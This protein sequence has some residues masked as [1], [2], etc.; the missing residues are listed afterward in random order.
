MSTLSWPSWGTTVSVQ[1]ADPAALRSARR[2]VD[3]CLRA[4]EKAADGDRARSE[5]QRLDR[6]G[7]AP[8]T[9]SPLLAD[10][11]A[12]ALDAAA[13]TEG[14]CD[15]TVGTSTAVLAARIRADQVGDRSRFPVCGASSATSPLRPAR[16]WQ[17]VRV[18][19]RRVVVP[20]GIHLDL[21][22][23]AT[24]FLASGAAVFAARHLGTGVLVDLGGDVATAGTSPSGGW[25]VAVGSP[26]G[27][28]P[29]SG[30][31]QTG[32]LQTV[33]LH[34]SD[35]LSTAGGHTVVDPRTGR[36]VPQIWR[37][38]SVRTMD[39][40]TAKAL[41]I[42]A[43]VAGQNAPELLE[44]RGVAAQLEYLDGGLLQLTGWDEQRSHGVR[45]H[46][47]TAS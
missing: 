34:P 29:A 9:V 5:I 43:H 22:A 12:A 13:M 1:T 47:A 17:H 10:L 16:G 14:A 21:S 15:P 30:G 33:R 39:C 23:T 6:S 4:G 37:R 46:L 20:V 42:A 40:V 31:P 45:R 11:V 2:L 7:G 24:A 3:L 28:D 44:S 25:R 41:A 18:D 38:I 26:D 19:G 36:V 8:V 35:A 32:R 27:A